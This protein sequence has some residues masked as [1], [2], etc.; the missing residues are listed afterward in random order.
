MFHAQMLKA[1]RFSF[2]TA[3]YDGTDDQRAGATRRTDFRRPSAQIHEAIAHDSA[4]DRRRP[5]LAVLCARF[6]TGSKPGSSAS[7]V[8][9]PAIDEIRKPSYLTNQKLNVDRR[10][11]PGRRRRQHPVGGR[12][13]AQGTMSPTCTRRCRH[14]RRRVR[15]SAVETATRSLLEIALSSAR[16]HTR[17]STPTRMTHRSRPS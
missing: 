17:I 4:Q 3:R 7:E 2:S 13:T 12:G 5:H 10:R 6:T 9:I 1:G 15:P 14:H 8:F 11:F 16:T